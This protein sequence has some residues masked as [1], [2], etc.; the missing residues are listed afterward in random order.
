MKRSQICTARLVLTAA[1]A[2]CATG[3]LAN[4]TNDLLMRNARQQARIRDDLAASRMDP[5]RAAQVQQ[6][7]ADVYRMQAQMLAD[8]TDEQREQLRQAQRDLA[9]AIAWAEKHPAH[10]RATA[11]DRTRLEV[12]ST[13]NAEQQR[14]IARGLASGRIAKEQVAPLENV[15]AEIATAQFEAASGSNVTLEEARSI[16]GAQNVQDYSIKND[17]H[18]SDVL[19]LQA[20]AK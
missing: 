1:A 15:Q 14:L 17:P 12:A 5:L 18:V 8:A 6:R 19:L 9:G 16:Q 11:M 13:R 4:P 2:A 3:A 20:E 10:A 7:A